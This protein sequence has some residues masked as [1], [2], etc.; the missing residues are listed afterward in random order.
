[1]LLHFYIL[2]ANQKSALNIF[3]LF[4]YSSFWRYAL[5]V[6]S[7]ILMVLGTLIQLFLKQSTDIIELLSR[8][9]P[10]HDV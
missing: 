9:L 6:F 7:C 3:I 1:M 10:V 5:C 8:S 2:F 4:C